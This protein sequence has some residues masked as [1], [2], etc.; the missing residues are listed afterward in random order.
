VGTT[1]R[2]LTRFD[3]YPLPDTDGRGDRDLGG[4]LAQRPTSLIDG[5][6]EARAGAHPSHPLHLDCLTVTTDPVVACL[7]V[8][9][10]IH[11]AHPRR[12]IGPLPSAVTPFASHSCSDG[13]APPEFPV[14]L[15]SLLRLTECLGRD[16][17]APARL[18]R[19]P[20]L[21]STTLACPRRW[22]LA[23]CPGGTPSPQ[24]GVSP[25]RRR[26]TDKGARRLTHV[27]L[28]S[29]ALNSQVSGF[30]RRGEVRLPPAYRALAP[31]IAGAHSIPGPRK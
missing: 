18:S 7:I 21:N 8:Q 25:G 5:P 2:G 6:A 20:D 29:N 24:P 13:N 30:P 17:K 1:A 11:P 14:P 4:T 26:R 22:P 3:G 28:P 27:F 12:R 23:A 31:P 10:R 19:Q 9:K 16:R 15:A